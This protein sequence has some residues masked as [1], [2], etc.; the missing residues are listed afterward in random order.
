MEEIYIIICELPLKNS[1]SRPL[2]EVPKYIALGCSVL[3]L[4]LGLAEIPR[5]KSPKDNTMIKIKFFI[6]HCLS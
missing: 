4:A 1:G 2:R 3:A 5:T 6:A